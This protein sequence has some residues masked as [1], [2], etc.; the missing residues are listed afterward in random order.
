MIEFCGCDICNGNTPN[1]CLED[2]CEKCLDL[3]LDCR[4]ERC[5]YCVQLLEECVCTCWD[6]FGKKS[7]CD[8]E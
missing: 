1:S 2:K 4:C 3:L 6:C 7:D 8:C 5:F